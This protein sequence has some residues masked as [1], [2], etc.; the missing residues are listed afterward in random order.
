MSKDPGIFLLDTRR[1]MLLGLWTLTEVARRAAVPLSTVSE[2]LNG[3]VNPT[4]DHAM[5][6]AKALGITAEV[7]HRELTEM[8]QERAAARERQEADQWQQRRDAIERLIAE[9]GGQTGKDSGRSKNEQA[10]ATLAAFA[11]GKTRLV[12][13][14]TSSRSPVAPEPANTRW[15]PRSPTDVRGPRRT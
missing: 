10:F 6:I 8:R 13:K 2:I 12:D 9:S 14:P 11:W 15:V 3:R 7:L 4:F 5:A 1:R